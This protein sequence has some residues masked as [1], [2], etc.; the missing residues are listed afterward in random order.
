MKLLVLMGGPNRIVGNSPYPVFLTE[1]KGETLLEKLLKRYEIPELTEY[2]FCIKQ[3]DADS[4]NLD[5]IIKSIIPS[6]QIVILRG[7]TRGAVCTAL[8]ARDHIDCEEELLV[9]SVDDFIDSDI[10]KLVVQYRKE[11]ADVGIAN[12]NSI[13]PRYSFVRRDADG[14]ISG[15]AEKKPVSREALASFFYFKNGADFTDCAFN[16]IRKDCMINNS[17]YISQVLNEMLLRNKKICA[18]SINGEMFHSFKSER[19]LLSLIETLSAKE[20]I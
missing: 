3:D 13:H 15:F 9:V 1:I 16:V 5:A 7:S 12:F 6:A 8:M 19:Q 2:I 14:N 10:S 11:N 18:V 20:K 4:Y 17:F